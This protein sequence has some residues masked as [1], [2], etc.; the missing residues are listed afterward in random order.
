MAI[1]SNLFELIHTMFKIKTKRVERKK[2]NRMKII[3]KVNNQHLGFRYGIRFSIPFL[4][5]LSL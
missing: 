2:G 1:T 5:I 4:L 3:R